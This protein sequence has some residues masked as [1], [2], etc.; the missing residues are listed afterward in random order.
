MPED[1]IFPLMDR[2]APLADRVRD[3]RN[4]RGGKELGKVFGKVLTAE[5]EDQR[6]K[7]IED[8]GNQFREGLAEQLGVSEEDIDTGLV[9]ELQ[10]TAMELTPQDVLTRKSLVEQGIIEVDDGEDETQTFSKEDIS[11]TEE[12]E[13]EESDEDTDEEAD[14]SEEG[15]EEESEEPDAV[16]F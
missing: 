4:G 13:E 7:V 5:D 14:G 2:R 12:S 11:T 9:A 15:S 6:N 16:S 1:S 8:L 3:F 10:Q